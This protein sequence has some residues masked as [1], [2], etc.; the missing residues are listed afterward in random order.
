MKFQSLKRVDRCSHRATWRMRLRPQ[1][2]FN[3]SSGL[4]GVLTPLPPQWP[5]CWPCFNPS[6]GL[7]GVLTA[8]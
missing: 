8:S 7:I 4:I 2:R 3:P 1:A 6:S 5:A